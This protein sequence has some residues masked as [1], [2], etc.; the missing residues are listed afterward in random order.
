VKKVKWTVR[1]DQTLVLSVQ[2]Y[3]MSSWPLV[4]A[5]VPGRTGKQCRERWINQL[6]L[7]L[8]CEK[9]A[10]QE[11]ATLLQQQKSCGNCWSKMI[12]FLPHR[13]ANAIKN[14]WCWLTRQRTDMR[15]CPAE[16][17]AADASARREEAPERVDIFVAYIGILLVTKRP[18]DRHADGPGR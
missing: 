17:T 9:W 13:S 15:Q 12:Q 16:K 4:A 11:D 6:D 3:G 1:E 5:E 8:N 10:P 14:R 2:K 7:N 18:I